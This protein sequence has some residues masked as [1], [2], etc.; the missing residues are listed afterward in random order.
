MSRKKARA[1]VRGN[2]NVYDEWEHG[3]IDRNE[4]KAGLKR[5]DKRW[6]E[7]ELEQ[8]RQ[9]KLEKKAVE[10][11]GELDRGSKGRPLTELEEAWLR[12]DFLLANIMEKKAYEFMEW[13]RINDPDT[14][15]RLYRKFMSKNMM[16]YAQQYVDYFAQ[17]YRAPRLA[18]LA[19][20]I[21]QYKKIKGIKTIFTIKHKGEDEHD[22]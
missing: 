20:V 4:Q 15:M 5:R 17:G 12:C 13:Q 2:K 3:D 8:I 7:I 18:T 19:E 10:M 21:K 1:K 9:R 6:K 16:R 22:L 14:Y 11:A